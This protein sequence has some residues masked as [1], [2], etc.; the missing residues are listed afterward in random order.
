MDVFRLRSEL[1]SV[2]DKVL[3]QNRSGES[4]AAQIKSLLG[5]RL[6]MRRI[7]ESEL[8]PGYKIFPTSN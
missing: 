4:F 5:G 1:Y 6:I 8:E 3:V 7:D 2:G